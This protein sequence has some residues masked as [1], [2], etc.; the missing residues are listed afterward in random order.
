MTTSSSN[1]MD[2]IEVRRLEFDMDKIESQNLVWSFTHP[3]FS[4]YINALAVHIPYFERYLVLGMRK[5]KKRIHD[6]RLQ[7]DVTKIIGQEAHHAK[8]FMAINKVLARRYPEVTQLDAQAKAAFKKP[9]NEENLKQTIG[10]IAGYE[11]FTFLGGMIILQGYD[12]WM[13]DAEPVLRSVWLWHQV[14]EVEHG[15]VAFEVYK[16][17]YGEHEWYRKWMV[18]KAFIH[19]GME[20]GRAYFPMVR[21]EGFFNSP[22][23]LVH[24]ISFFFSFSAR[25]AYAALPVLSKNYHPR[26]HPLCSTNQSPIAVSWTN[27]Y[28]LGKDVLEIDNATMQSVLKS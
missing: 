11:T 18:L 15:A 23:K 2:N 24:C 28:S 16:Y 8:N 5:I 14:E 21:K 12:K 7:S 26:N 6:E 25:L 10:F 17:L 27:Y 9:I 22:K 4:I 20:A 13:K 19:I 1:A 3:L